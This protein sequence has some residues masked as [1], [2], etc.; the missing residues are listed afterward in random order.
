MANILLLFLL[1]SITAI[2]QNS[3]YIGVGTIN[4]FANTTSFNEQFSNNNLNDIGLYYGN[5][6]I[7]NEYLKTTIQVSY[8]NNRVVLAQKGSNKFELHQNIGFAIKP[9]FYFINHSFLLKAGMFGVYLFDKDTERGNQLDR[10]DESY[11]YGFE[12][13]YAF[14]KKV[15]GSLGFIFS[16]FES[17]SNWT[18]HTLN[19]FSIL[20]LSVY[21]KLY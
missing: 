20:H 21:Y 19:N 12:Y 9:G 7:I 6:F 17:I 16:K 10:F 8:L 2:G 5:D 13:N 3:A 1:L 15:T 18:D 11:F 14:T 4:T